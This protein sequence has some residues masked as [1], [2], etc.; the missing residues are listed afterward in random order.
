MK[1]IPRDPHKA[2]IDAFHWVP[3]HRVDVARTKRALMVTTGGIRGEIVAY[4]LW[5]ETAT[6]LIVPRAFFPPEVIGDTVDTR[7]QSYQRIQVRSRITLDAKYPNE[8]TQ[9][10]AV[11]ALLRANG[12]TLQLRCGGG[13]TVIALHLVAATQVPT[14]IV[15]PEGALLDQWRR[16][17]EDYL[18]L[19]EGVGLIRGKI[20]DWQK[21]VVLATYTTLANNAGSYPEEMRRWFG[22]VFYDEGHHLS[23]AKWCLAATI[24][25][26]KRFVLSA[27]PEREDGTHLLAEA[28]CGPVLY[29]NLQQPLKPTV[30]FV[31]TGFSLDLLD[32]GVASYVHDRTGEVH[33]GMLARYLGHWQARNAYIVGMLRE[34][35]RGGRHVLYLGHSVEGLVNLLAEWVG[36]PALN[37]LSKPTADELGFVGIIPQELSK[38]KIK[39]LRE[40]IADMEETLRTLPAPSRAVQSRIDGKRQLLRAHD[41]FVAIRRAER[42]RLRA[43]LDH[44]IE[45]SKDA[46]IIIG[47]VDEKERIRLLREKQL[48]FAIYRIGQEGLDKGSLDTVVFG[49]PTK[50]PGIVQ[51]VLGRVLRA[52]ENKQAPLGIVLEDN[53]MPYRRLCAGLRQLL[54]DWPEDSG[55]TIP[56]TLTG[57]PLWAQ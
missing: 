34:L 55:G 53:V 24:I 46:G 49:E 7:P 12:G 25:Y 16:A 48:V 2:Y 22:Q 14:L 15:A 21:P 39:E 51:Q 44:L 29:K 27:T 13:K 11:N 9:R 57:H 5:R 28:H 41:A 30:E 20:F 45:S 32:A 40:Q 38:K 42:K 56:Y 19:P 23:A 36:A 52:D 10:D 54:T 31:W 26:G 47:D 18:E 6:H 50:K 43:H 33:H 17:V 3:K 1:F 4:N 8:T 35:I 37:T